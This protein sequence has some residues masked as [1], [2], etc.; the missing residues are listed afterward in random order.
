MGTPF[1]GWPARCVAVVKSVPNGLN[2][3][4]GM[5]GGRGGGTARTAGTTPSSNILAGYPTPALGARLFGRHFAA[6]A[7]RYADPSNPTLLPAMLLEILEPSQAL[8]LTVDALSRLQ[9]IET[10]RR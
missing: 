3:D 8:R 10:T 5:G 9:R 1:L 4:R 6:Q 7:F 2:F